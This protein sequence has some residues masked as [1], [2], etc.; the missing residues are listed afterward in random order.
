MATTDK[1]IT[2]KWD[3]LIDNVGSDKMIENIYCYLDCDT[4][5]KIVE[6]FEEDGYLDFYENNNEND[7]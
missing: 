7:Y 3:Y 6:W 2:S 5:A 4:I 1:E